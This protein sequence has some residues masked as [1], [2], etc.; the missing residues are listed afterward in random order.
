MEEKVY[1]TMS[2]SGALS[3]ALGILS[4]AGGIVC[5]ILLVV[6][7]GRLLKNKGKILL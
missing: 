3:I 2:H 1:K 7:G 4:M 6:S 5:G